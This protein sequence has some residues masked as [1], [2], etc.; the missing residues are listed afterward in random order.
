MKIVIA[1]TGDTAVHLA[2][3][4]SRE[5]QDV[6]VLGD[7][8]SV[9]QEL[10]GRYNLLTYQGNP[11]T[12]S[13]IRAAGGGGCDLFIAVTPCE[14]H[15]LISAELAKWLGASRTM[16]R[17][18]N[19]ELLHEDARRHM[20]SLGVDELVYPERLASHEIRRALR[21]PWLRALYPL[22]DGA[23]SVGS[24]RIPH[25][26][27]IAG[28]RLSDFDKTR[29]QMHIC[30]IKRDG[31]I[32]IPGGAD[33]IE[34]GDRIYFTTAPGADEQALM[35]L[36]GRQAHDIH[37]V[38]I[39]GAGK[40]TRSLVELIHNDYKVTVIDPDRERCDR[41]ASACSG[42]TVVCADPRD[43]DVLREEGIKHCDAFIAL[44]DSSEKNIVS[45]LVARTLGVPYTVAQIE[46]I[47]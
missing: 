32:L 33:S 21:H 39:C 36:F 27:P 44:S 35:R 11:V 34:A 18:D 24:V 46:D 5:N 26:A 7:D 23:I 1:G 16:A 28:L 13:H 31:E 30:A 9:L 8:R 15:N 6:V 38:M 37:N 43:V 25:R 2:K 41:M 47:Q 17:I 10:D 20:A 40:M 42:V 45:S 19:D 29:Y 3:M 12:P 14:N 22:H 4:L